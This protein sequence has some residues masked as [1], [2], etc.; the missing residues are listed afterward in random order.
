MSELKIAF[1]TLISQTRTPLNLYL[2]I[3]GLDEYEGDEEDVIEI[4][5]R[6]SMP[7]N[8]KVCYSSRPHQAFE[9][10]FVARPGLK[11]QDLTIP[12]M[13]QYVHDKLER[14]TRMQQLTAK[15][16]EATTEL[17]EEIGYAACGVFLWVRLVVSSLLRGLGKHD[18]IQH[19]QLRLRET[20]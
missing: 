14:H 9:D 3:D 16:P 18:D 11:L 17:I 10:A 5:G 12:D 7:D 6:A 1:K 4:F 20:S 2:F 8:V 13:R 19:L 15:E